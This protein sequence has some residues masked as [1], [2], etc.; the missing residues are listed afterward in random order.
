VENGQ[1]GGKWGYM[2]PSLRT[3]SNL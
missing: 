1:R 3:A 2:R